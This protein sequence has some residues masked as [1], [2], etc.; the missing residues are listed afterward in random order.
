M[1]D[2]SGNMLSKSQAETQMRRLY[3]SILK[4]Y[5]DR[6]FVYRTYKYDLI[7]TAKVVEYDMGGLVK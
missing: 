3:G 4:K 5:V 7:K 2:E 1:T 6:L